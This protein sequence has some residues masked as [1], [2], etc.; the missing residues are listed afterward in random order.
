MKLILRNICRV[1]ESVMYRDAKWPPG[2]EDPFPQPLVE[3]LL[4]QFQNRFRGT[5][6]ATIPGG[7]YEVDYGSNRSDTIHLGD[8]NWIAFGNG[9]NDTIF[10]NDG[11][12]ILFG[13]KGNDT[14]VGNDGFNLLF[15][16]KGNDTL[17][18][19]QHGNFLDGGDGK[20]L[21][22]GGNG[23]DILAGGAGNDTL[24]GGHGVDTFVFASG[25]GR[26]VVMDFGDGDILQIQRNINGLHVADADDLL[27]RIHDDHQGNAVIDLGHG[28]SVTLMGIKAEDIHNNPDGYIKVH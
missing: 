23:D 15:G 6:M 26:D 5:S 21:L 11:T 20:D 27:S 19:G 25:G 2:V 16:E 12:D 14:L 9:G 24:F 18:G 1:I 7:S 13:G 28:D 3:R 4:G 10:G 17:I 22:V 8:G